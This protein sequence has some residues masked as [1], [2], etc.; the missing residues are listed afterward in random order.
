M[1]YLVGACLMEDIIFSGFGLDHN[2]LNVVFL[3]MTCSKGG[4]LVVCR[5]KSVSTV[6]IAPDINPHQG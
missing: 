4:C 6:E 3:I 5:A 2:G 1:F